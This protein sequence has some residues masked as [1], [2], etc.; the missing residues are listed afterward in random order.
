MIIIVH[1]FKMNFKNEYVL[2]VFL[3]HPSVATMKRHKQLHSPKYLKEQKAMILKEAEQLQV[4]DS[5]D[6]ASEEEN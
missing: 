6:S 3:Y 1:E 4:I 5:G 2:F